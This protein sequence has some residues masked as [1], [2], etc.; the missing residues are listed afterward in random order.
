[1]S[2]VLATQT[3]GKGERGDGGRFA[4]QTSKFRDWV[5]ADGTS[6]FPAEAGRYHLYV[7]LACPWAHRTIIVR[8]AQGPRRTRS[9]C[10]SSTRSA[11][12]AAGR[13]PTRRGTTADPLNGW[14]YLSE[15]YTAT[16]PDFDGRVTVPVL[17]DKQTEPDR[18][19]RVGRHHRDAELARSTPSPTSPS[20]TSTPPR[21]A[22]EIDAINDRG[23]RQR[24][25]RRLPRRLRDARRRPTR[26][27]CSRC[28]TRSTSSRS[29]STTRRYLLGDRA[30]AR[31]LAPVHDAGA[32]RPGVR[33]PLQVQ[34]PADRRLPEPVRLPARP[35]PEPGV[36][37]TVDFDQIKR[38]YYLT[39]D[40]HQPDAGSCRRAR[41][42]DLTHRTAGRRL[43][44]L[45]DTAGAATA[46]RG[47]VIARASPRARRPAPPRPR[48]RAGRGCARRSRASRGTAGRSRTPRRAPGPAL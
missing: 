2:D 27:R 30:D 21:C 16:D 44:A 4:R 47:R 32:L 39:H 13:S 1:M 35:L 46:R 23:L 5:T 19:Q 17:W 15:A 6:G 42:L 28:S 9:A 11:T 33:R 31:R 3:F 37:E 22:D 12:S 36:A 7:S 41:S 10:R 43:A 40:E 34:P 38:H 48:R 45:S 18:Q 24:Q 14:A 29:G 26:R 20:S 8:A 25:Q